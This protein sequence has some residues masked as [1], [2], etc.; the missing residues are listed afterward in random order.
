MDTII[1]T[2][3]F[4]DLLNDKG[5]SYIDRGFEDLYSDLSLN[6]LYNDVRVKIEEEIYNYFY[7]MVIPDE[8]TL[9]DY[10]VLSLREKDLI[11]TFNWDPLLFQAL[12]RNAHIK[13][14][15]KIVTNHN[16]DP[17]VI[18]ILTP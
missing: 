10:L 6:P 9:Y 4:E 14:L 13:N 18:G 11:A 17:S 7:N 1:G 8:P 3:G 12:K 16:T 2:L 5:I 15:P